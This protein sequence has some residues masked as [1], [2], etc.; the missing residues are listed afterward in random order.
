MPEFGRN[1]FGGA[2]VLAL[3]AFWAAPAWADSEGGLGFAHGIAEAG[4]IF[5]GTVADVA[6]GFSTPT[7][8]A[9]IPIAH[10]FVTYRISRVLKG[11]FDGDSLTLRFEGGAEGDGTYLLVEGFPLFDVGETDVLFVGANGASPCPLAGCGRG[12]FRFVEG[13]TYSD[14]GQ[15]VVDLDG[16]ITL[17]PERDIPEANTHQLDGATLRRVTDIPLDDAGRA[18]Q[19]ERRGVHL[20]REA[21]LE[22]VE[23]AV[24]DLPDGSALAP[25]VA[26]VDPAEPFAAAPDAVA[27]FPRA[28]PDRF[29]GHRRGSGEGLAASDR[30]EEV[31]LWL[32]GG[33]PV[34]DERVAAHLARMREREAARA[35]GH[36]QER[37]HRLQRG[38]HHR[39]FG[40]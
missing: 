13:M 38:R 7:R 28:R 23:R 24:A 32:N 34:L 21:F 8:E 39:S 31:F 14:P 3:L 10:T 33:N 6:G 9:P 1:S 40:P 35:G 27:P 5:E 4:L 22:A 12:R 25:P 17:G 16:L 37:S 15:E 20:S 26:S 18:P 30:L 29:H 19:P 11:R 36:G 2:L